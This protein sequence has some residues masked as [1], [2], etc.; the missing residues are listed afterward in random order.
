MQVNYF[1]SVSIFLSCVKL[2]L[3]SFDTVSTTAQ[4]HG[5]LFGGGV[6]SQTSKSSI[7]YLSSSSNNLTVDS[8]GSNPY[9]S[10]KHNTGSTTAISAAKKNKPDTF[11]S[12]NFIDKLSGLFYD[13]P[14]KRGTPSFNLYN[15]TAC[16]FKLIFK[17]WQESQSELEDIAKIFG[18][19]DNIVQSV[20]KAIAILIEMQRASN[21]CIQL[22]HLVRMFYYMFDIGHM[23]QRDRNRKT[24]IDTIQS[25]IE[26]IEL[27]RALNDIDIYGDSDLDTV[28]GNLNDLLTTFKNDDYNNRD[29]MVNAALMK[30]LM[31]INQ[32]ENDEFNYELNK[33]R[34]SLSKYFLEEVKNKQY[35]I[36]GSAIAKNHVEV[37]RN[38]MPCVFSLFFNNME[39][40]EILSMH[41]LVDDEKNKTQYVN[42]LFKNTISTFIRRF[43][44]FGELNSTE[45][46]N[47]DKITELLEKLD[48]SKTGLE[49]TEEPST[50]KL[51]IKELLA[52]T[53]TAI[54]AVLNLA[55]EEDVEEWKNNS[56]FKFKNFQKDQ[57]KEYYFNLLT[58][59]ADTAYLLV[60]AFEKHFLDGISYEKFHDGGNEVI[61]V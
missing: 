59:N 32:T 6:M 44:N 61:F 37:I 27:D 50:P 11:T 22:C 19:S 16:I 38:T 30:G 20:N 9:P 5:V 17:T 13:N 29:I 49:N 1:Y 39:L 34:R 3:G 12:K 7:P 56:V 24:V 28:V 40:L 46:S 47:L 51:D 52:Q 18:I 4:S 57:N 21:K 42:N 15:A 53:E 8:S 43:K 35:E 26:H 41:T 58:H 45:I 54:A 25:L 14:G 33:L 48:T 36:D 60:R 10:L 2:S 31:L 23:I 55:G